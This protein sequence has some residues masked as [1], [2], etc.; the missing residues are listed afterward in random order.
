M[1]DTIK[2]LNERYHIEVRHDAVLDNSEKLIRMWKDELPGRYSDPFEISLRV[3][4]LAMALDEALAHACECL[5]VKSSEML[6]LFALRRG[7]P[8][9]SMR[10]TEILRETAVTSGTVT[11]R[12]DQLVKRNLADRIPDPVD[13]RGF[14]VQLTSHGREITDRALEVSI[15]SAER[16]L[17]SLKKAPFAME[18]FCELL[19]YYEYGLKA[20]IA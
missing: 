18:V 14:L 10:P 4:R 6:L 16:A 20:E 5:G 12:I 1:L 7:G 8:P 19:K 13:R 17:E 2:G 15:Q 11:Y 3:R 9:Y